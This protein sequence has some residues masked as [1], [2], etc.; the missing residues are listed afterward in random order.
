MECLRW[1]S[2][3]MSVSLQVWLC[4]LSIVFSSGL[5]WLVSVV[6]LSLALTSLLDR[7]ALAL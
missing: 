7:L 6:G 3:L 2:R 4:V 1:A 5:S